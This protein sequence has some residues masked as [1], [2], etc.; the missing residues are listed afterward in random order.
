ML[1]SAAGFL[2]LL[3]MTA[4]AA[5]VLGGGMAAAVTV[6]SAMRAG[7]GRRRDC[8]GG[9]SSGQKNPGHDKKTPIR[10]RDSTKMWDAAFLRPSSL[11]PR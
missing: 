6:A 4:S 7:R 9:H 8:Q 3:A 1:A 2:R 5:V 11:H 10:F